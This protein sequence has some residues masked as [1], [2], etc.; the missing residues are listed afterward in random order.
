MLFANILAA[1]YV[2]WCMSMSAYCLAMATIV[3]FKESYE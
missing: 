1:A 3:T 2:L